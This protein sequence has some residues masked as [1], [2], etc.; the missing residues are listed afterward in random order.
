MSRDRAIRTWRNFSAPHRD[1]FLKAFANDLQPLRLAMQAVISEDDVAFN[2]KV[3]WLR[4]QLPSLF[5]EISKSANSAKELEQILT[6]AFTRGYNARSTA[7]L[8]ATAK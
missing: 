3:A 6:A 1:D 4:S 8:A 5:T 2:S 7:E